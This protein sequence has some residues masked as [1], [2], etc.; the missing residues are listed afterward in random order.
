VRW[1]AIVNGTAKKQRDQKIL[2]LVLL[3]V[4]VMFAAVIVVGMAV[5]S[6]WLTI[7]GFC[8]GMPTFF[9]LLVNLTLY[10]ASTET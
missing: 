1:T 7:L 5:D 4:V 10:L 2:I 8:G 3:A 9:A 6:D